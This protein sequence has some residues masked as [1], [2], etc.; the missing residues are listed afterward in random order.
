MCYG[1]TPPPRRPHDGLVP[2]TNLVR[3]CFIEPFSE[4]SRRTPSDL[5]PTA[6]VLDAYYEEDPASEDGVSRG[7]DLH[8]A[9]AT[10]LS[11]TADCV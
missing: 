4:G 1:Q 8:T 5:T 10:E 3:H 6:R 9:M 2:P 7:L 11:D